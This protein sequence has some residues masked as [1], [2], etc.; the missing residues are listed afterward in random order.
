MATYYVSKSTHNDCA[1]GSDSNNGTSKLTPWL[2][3]AKVSASA[4]DGDTIY[5]NDGAYADAELGGSNVFSLNTTKSLKMYPLRDYAVVLKSSAASAQIVSLTGTATNEMIFGKFVI[6]GEIPGAPGTYQPT[7]LSIPNTSGDCTLTL[8]GT[9]IQNCATQNILNSRRRGIMTLNLVFGGLMAQGIASTT[10]GA[11][12]A[13]MTVLITGLVLD[14]VTCSTNAL[15]RVLDFT[16]LSTSSQVYSLTVQAVTGTITAPAALGSS[17]AIALLV[18]TGIDGVIA[19]NFNATYTCFSTGVTCYGIYIKNSARGATAT[20]NRPIVRNNVITGNAPSEYIISIGDTT[21]SY[22]VDNGY[23]YGNVITAPYYASSTPHCIALGN[24]TGGL[25]RSNRTNGGYVG[26]LAGINQGGL[27]TGNI[28]VGCYGYALYSKGSGGTTGPMICHNT[29]ILTN[30]YGAA[31]GAAMGA[32]AQ[33]ATNNSAVT[34]QNNNLYALSDLYRFAEVGPSQ[35]ATF[36]RN[37]HYSAG[38]VGFTSPW[39]YQASTYTTFAAWQA[40]QETT[41]LNANPLFLNVGAEDYRLDPASSLVRAGS[42]ASFYARD[43][44]GYRV[45]LPPDIGAYQSS[46]GDPLTVA[47]VAR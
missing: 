1:V 31:R 21:I 38:P 2:T 18:A 22:D 42:G 36:I 43:F 24:V 25:V 41:A 13:A 19:E 10:S 7:G 29:V 37:N 8:A 40:A 39:A 44:R 6:D 11:D 5:V 23:V 26:F 15:A 20:A 12:T 16:R 35:T 30:V 14:N 3:L 45:F 4:A 9:R 17:A 28:S 27:I 46:P 34:F 33:G 47:R 32:S